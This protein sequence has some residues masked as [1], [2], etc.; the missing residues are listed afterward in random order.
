MKKI[1]VFLLIFGITFSSIL[2]Q[3]AEFDITKEYSI[4]GTTWFD[5]AHY[6]TT[7]D[8]F[9][10]ANSIA[11]SGNLQLRSYM[12]YAAATLAIKACLEQGGTVVPGSGGYRTIYAA[13]IGCEPD[14]HGSRYEEII[15]TFDGRARAVIRCSVP[16][17]CVPKENPTVDFKEAG[18]T[19]NQS[20]SQGDQDFNSLWGAYQTAAQLAGISLL[21]SQ[22]PYEHM[23]RFVDS[24]VGGRFASYTDNNPIYAGTV[25]TSTHVAPIDASIHYPRGELPRASVTVKAG[26]VRVTRPRPTVCVDEP[27]QSEK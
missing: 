23:N 20:F 25:I 10:G 21:V 9:W 6:Q 8:R 5:R 2:T 19:A 7:C 17:K 4:G 16:E 18:E 24:A 11:R 22:P 15:D 1:S 12:I 3:A 14:H 26:F 13:P 27:T